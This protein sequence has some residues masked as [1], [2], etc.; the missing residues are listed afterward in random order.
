MSAKTGRS[1]S[2]QRLARLGLL[3]AVIIVLTVL[4]V[5]NIPIGPI[6]A[7]IY[8]IPVIIGAVILGPA[9][10]FILGGFWGMLGFFLALGGHTTD[11]VA[12]A[13]VQQSP[14]IYLVIAFVPRL[15]MGGLTGFFARLMAK[16]FKKRDYVGF[17]LT[18]AA[19]SLL[20]TVLYLGALYLL[21]RPI[22][23]SVYEIDADAVIGLVLGVAA[24][25]GLLEAALS[26]VLISAICKAL[27]KFL[28]L[29]ESGADRS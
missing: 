16:I 20:N 5:G 1:V 26:L 29:E 25:N 3:L 12:L 4:N 27:V 7:T 24:T 28:P 6:V 14:L 21:I 19:G 22:L 17:A 15:L 11:A 18:G 13:A 10:G 9:A 23:A 8:H 2:V